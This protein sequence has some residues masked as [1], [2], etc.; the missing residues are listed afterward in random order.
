V[1][2]IYYSVRL[3][4]TREIPWMVLY[5]I[6]D[7]DTTN[8]VSDIIKAVK[9]IRANNVCG[10]NNIPAFLVVGSIR[11]VLTPLRHVFNLMLS[12]ICL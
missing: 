3:I 9:K 11:C 8:I 7:K 5:N 2:L 1:G 4:N 6:N 12:T 10:P